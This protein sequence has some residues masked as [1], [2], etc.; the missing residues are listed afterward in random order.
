MCVF[1]VLQKLKEI[2]FPKAEELKK[3]LLTQYDK[4]YAEYLVRKVS[5]FLCRLD[6]ELFVHHEHFLTSEDHSL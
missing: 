2:A 3:L 5:H 6:T 4:D 1:F